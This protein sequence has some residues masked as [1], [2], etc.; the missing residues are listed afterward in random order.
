MMEPGECEAAGGG[1]ARPRGDWRRPLAAVLT[2][3]LFAVLAGADG[4]APA[5]DTEA[6][7]AADPGDAPVEAR[8]AAADSAAGGI[9][10][11]DATADPRRI[12][13][14]AWPEQG[15]TCYVYPGYV[16]LAWGSPDPEPVAIVRKYDPADGPPDC[17][18]DS[19]AGDFVI[20]NDWVE[21][22]CGM[23]RNLVFI[24]SGTSEIRSLIIYDAE[25]RSLAFQ[26]DG[27]GETDGWIDDVTVRMWKLA[28]TNG[29]RSLCPD[30]PDWLGVGVDSLY[31]VNLESF[32]LKPLGEWRC[33]PLQ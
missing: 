29:P 31:A 30:I 21:Y 27:C 25:S 22:F 4:D 12:F 5:I 16:V 20:W 26:I 10:V 13:V 18:P 14:P 2:V 19:L 17:T 28:S 11:L 7:R 8:L 23:W 24:D 15:G 1:A 32:S 6:D 33:N 3:A 9:R